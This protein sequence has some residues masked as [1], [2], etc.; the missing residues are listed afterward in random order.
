MSYRKYNT[1]GRLKTI[2]LGSYFYPEYFSKINNA[3]VRE[4]LM[5]MAQEINED[6]DQF[7]NI[8]KEFGAT[9]I[10][11][12]QPTGYFDQD[13]PYLPSLQVRNTHAVV[14]DQMYQINPDWHD[15]I[16]PVLKEFCPDIINLVDDNDKFYYKSMSEAKSNHNQEL[17]LWYSYE[18]YQELSGSDWPKFDDYVNGQRSTIPAI[19]EEIQSF[20][21]VIEYETKELAPLQGP[22][23]IN[24]DDYIY[25]DAN[26]YCNYAN[27]FSD[28]ITDSRPVRQFTSK[29]GHVDGC[30]AVLGN[31]TILGIDQLINYKD[32]FPN[33]TVI[34]VPPESYQ[35]QIDEFKIMKEK[36][37]GAWWLAGEEHN[38]EFIN[39]VETHLK[40]WVGY[41][42]ESVFDV[43]V[44]P[45]DEHTI[46]VSN[47]TKD[48]QKQL[49]SRGIECIL[50]PWRHRFFVDGGLHCITLDLHREGTLKDYFPERRLT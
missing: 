6:L 49:S 1:Y 13:N 11:A 37:N 21:A 17:D 48:V 35:H 25:V 22:N 47:I 38:N 50:V 8:L 23:I 16:N 45:L 18:K 33:H 19:Q 40:P 32:Y 12:P 20:R 31:N 14:G 34:S 28:R 5:R 43:N 42:A 27:W 39:Y 4:P 44:L 15:P 24:T 9:V 36:V 29:A 10:R 41:V 3:N 46:C 26:E 2:M 30:F 7:G